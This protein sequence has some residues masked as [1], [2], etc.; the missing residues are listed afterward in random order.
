MG[1][2]RPPARAALDERRAGRCATKRTVGA[3]LPDHRHVPQARSETGDRVLSIEGSRQRHADVRHVGGLGRASR[4]R[5][6][7]ARPW[8]SGYAEPDPRDDLSGRDAA[9]KALI[10]A[11]LLGYRGPAPVAQD[12]VPR[13]LKRVPRAADFLDRL[14]AF[15]DEWAARA[16]AEARR[17]RV[18]RYRGDRDAARRC[19]RSLRRCRRRARRARS[20]A[21]ATSSPSRRRRYRTEPLVISGPGAGAE[22]TR[23]GH[24]ERH[25]LAVGAVSDAGQKARWPHDDQCRHESRDDAAA[26]PQQPRLRRG[27]RDAARA[28]GAAVAAARQRRSCSSARICSRSSATSCA[29]PTTASR[30]SPRRSARRG[31]IAASAGNHAQGV[32]FAARHLGLRAPHRHAADDARDQGRRGARHGRRSDRSSATATPTRRRTLRRARRRRPA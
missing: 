9:R 20:R 7:C 6:R 5:R 14:Q 22:V 23:G 25:L 31:V 15:D 4:S 11:R 27:A 16:A 30:T 2:L 29:A 12:L 28:G 8:S 21:R 13:A 1:E 24:P 3:G 17:G 10:L 32:A 26:D 19:R 18:L